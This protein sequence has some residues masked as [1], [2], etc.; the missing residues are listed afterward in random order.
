MYLFGREDDVCCVRSVA[1]VAVLAVLALHA[2]IPIITPAPHTRPPVEHTGQEM[3]K[4]AAHIFY[5]LFLLQLGPGVSFSLLQCIKH[6]Y[7]G[8]SVTAPWE[9]LQKYLVDILGVL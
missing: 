4:C 2:T 7:T 6:Q 5:I 3:A 8:T 1:V 9:K